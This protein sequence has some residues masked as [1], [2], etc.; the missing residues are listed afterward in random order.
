MS[1]VTTLDGK[2]YE[3]DE[4]TLAQYRIADEDVE[5]L[6]I[7]P[8]LPGVPAESHPVSGAA[9]Q[10]TVPAPPDPGRN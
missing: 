1:L 10:G 7:V 2:V 8:P 3:V 4:E 5:K 9:Q 6:T